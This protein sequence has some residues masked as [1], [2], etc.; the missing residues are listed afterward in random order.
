[1]KEFVES[2]TDVVLSQMAAEKQALE[3]SLCSDLLKEKE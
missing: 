3:C 2:L 1:M